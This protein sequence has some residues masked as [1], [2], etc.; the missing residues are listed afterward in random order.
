MIWDELTT[1]QLNEIDR[2][3]PV[4]LPMAATEQHGAHLPL[5]TDRLIGEHF[6]KSLHRSI[7]NEVLVLPTIS[8]GCSS[9]HMDFCGTLTISHN[10]FAKQVEEILKAVVK[11]GFINIVMF[12]SHGGNQAIGQ[13]ILEKLGIKYPKSN[14]FLISWW[15]LANEQ[16][17]KL[18]ETG[19]GGVGHAGEFE[20]SLLLL[21]APQLVQLDRVEKGTH[22]TSYNWAE[23]D[24][25]RAPIISYFRTLK[26]MTSNGVYGDP[27]AATAKKGKLITT[28]VVDCL[29]RM[30]KD[31]LKK[32]VKS[33]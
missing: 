4:F 24:M 10:T 20:T 19:A 8:V 32:Q 14:I 18:N 26:E 23:G 27:R 22:N 7:P 31:I 2:S 6:L 13:V 15:K 11:H 1:V 28:I 21:I 33:S 25:L 3:I 30:V 9:H 5:A 17:L 16:L 29:K 12:N